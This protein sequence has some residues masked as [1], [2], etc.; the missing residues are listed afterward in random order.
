MNIWNVPIHCWV[1]LRVRHDAEVNEHV[2]FTKPRP[3]EPGLHAPVNGGMRWRTRYH[4]AVEWCRENGGIAHDPD[5]PYT[6]EPPDPEP[7][8]A[9]GPYFVTSPPEEGRAGEIYVYKARALDSAVDGFTWS[10]EKS[11]PGMVVDR[12]TG[13]VTWT[14][15]G[16]GRVEVVLRARTVH[17]KE[18]RQ[19]WT[20]CIRKA[21]VV[22][23]A[24]PVARFREALRRKALR[25]SAPPLRCLWRE[26]KRRALPSHRPAAPPAERSP[27][28]ILLRI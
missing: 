25:T 1:A 4:D 23:R 14:P 26:P 16:G 28:A 8:P 17:G 21:V 19:G 9:P 22:R 6:R 11:P 27:P 13:E 18:A 3:L 24:V 5:K 2:E 15:S 12:Y 7:E 20:I 10:F